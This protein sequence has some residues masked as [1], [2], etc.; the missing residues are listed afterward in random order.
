[1]KPDSYFIDIGAVPERDTG[2]ARSF[3]HY[4]IGFA[5]SL[6]LT[7]GAY[8]IVTHHLF[9]F[10]TSVESILALA[11]V[12]FATQLVF[13]L[14]VSTEKSSRDRLIIFLWAC[15]LALILIS[16]SVWI[17]GSLSQRMQMSPSEMNAYMNNE[18][19]I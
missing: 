8:L 5:S 4:V 18:Q 19:G 2:T 9:S 10:Q 17:M 3:W 14:H 15:M 7:V 6:I 12:Q 11:F 13:F 16:G 1:M